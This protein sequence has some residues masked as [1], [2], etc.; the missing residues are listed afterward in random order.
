MTGV[1]YRL[2]A[3]DID[4]TLIGASG[5]LSPATIEA[6]G[7]LAAEGMAIAAATAR[8]YELALPTLAP[9]GDAV[10]AVIAA[11]GAD[12][13][14]ATGEPLAQVALPPEAA[15]ALARLCD[16]HDWRAVG[17]T[18]AGAFR[19][20][21]TPGARGPA[22]TLASLTEVD[23]SRTYV[24][25]PF[26]GPDDPA[27]PELEA[28]VRDRGLRGERALTS[29]GHEIVA[30]THADAGKGPALRR[31]CEA[32]G[33]TPADTVAFG[34]TEVDLPMIE[35]A[36]LGVAMGDA[37]P[38]VQAAAGMVTGTAEEDGVAAA[39]AR[40]RRPG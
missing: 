21:P 39:I 3:F 29:S 19:R 5:K 11:A 30:V 24:I 38:A 10:T 12:I 14:R 31:L 6:V 26:T 28:L 7:G 40:I 32:L 1:R 13:R 25:A 18:A 17:G 8:P 23:L 35:L 33:V 15:G 2:A 9:L 4:G 27:F 37:P 22:A 20:L 36:G 34:D 16:R